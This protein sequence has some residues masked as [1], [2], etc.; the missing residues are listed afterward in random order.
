MPGFSMPRLGSATM[1]ALAAALLVPALGGWQSLHTR[2]AIL[3]DAEQ[4]TRT[5]SHSLAQHAARTIEA[6]DLI[7]SDVV[8]RVQHPDDQDLQAYLV[9][10]SKT[11]HQS[12][13]IVVTNALGR[14]VSDSAALQPPIDIA[15]SVFFA[16]HASHDTGD[17][18][19]GGLSA[20]RLTNEPFLPLSKRITDKDGAF[21]GVAV[22]AVL[23]RFFQE[24]YRSLDVG[25]HGAVGL[26]DVGGH[27]LVR[28]PAA[29]ETHKP[30]VNQP[31]IADF[32]KDRTAVLRM[33]SPIDGVERITV[34]E[35]VDA[36]PLVVTAAVSMNDVLA[37][38]RRDVL[39]EGLVAGCA[40]FALAGFAFGLER[41]RRIA[42][43]SAA[44]RREADRKYRVL[45][46]T[47]SDVIMQISLDMRREYVSPAC[48]LMV[49]H[50]PEDMVGRDPQG[51]MH[52][53]DAPQVMAKLR[54]VVNGTAEGDTHRATYRVRHKDGHWVWVD[55]IANLLR[56]AHTGAPQTVISSL[57]DVTERERFARHLERAKATAE[58]AARLQSEFVANMSH[59]LRTPLTGILGIHDLLKRDPTLGPQQRR[60]LDMAR[61]AGRSLLSIVN[62]V[63]DFS[64]IE[65]GQLAIEQVPFRLDGLVE[66]CAEL[67]GESAKEKG[68]R[69]DTLAEG[70]D[71]RLVGDP[72]RLRQVLLNLTANAIKFTESGAVTV[73]ASYRSEAA[74]MRIEVTD[75]GIGIAEDKLPFMFARFSQADASTTRRYGGTG[76]GLAICKRIIE[77]MGGEIGVTS[78][79]GRGSTFWVDVPLLMAPAEAEQAKP[80]A[81]ES[82]LTGYRVLLAEDNLVNQEL[83]AAILTQRGH[84]VTPVDN[85]AA[86]AAAART[87]PRFDLILMDIQ[88][89]VMDGLTATGVIRGAEVTD[90]HTA[91][92]IIGLTANAMLEDVERCLQAGMTAH[93]AKPIDWAKLFATIDRVAATETKQDTP[94]ASGEEVPATVLHAAKLDDLVAVMGR[95]RV[96]R[97]LGA[98]VQDL[99]ARLLT[100]DGAGASGLRDQCHALV[101][102]AGQFGF[103]ELGRLCAEVEAAARSGGGLDRVSDL[104]AVAARAISAAWNYARAEAA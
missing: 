89:P 70:A 28:F 81:M 7:L 88:M 60:Y 99:D 54:A 29:P 96:A 45:A 11:L 19:V 72:A 67:T 38:W 41:Q 17:L 78:V 1:M 27:L 63:L 25:P 98:F 82:P 59:E 44:A 93:V 91:I 46:E 26:W 80:N 32:P 13:T 76:L 49:G 23:P 75:T 102:T 56:D 84:V 95:D 101:S 34:F 35:H 5:L 48:R 22:A 62:D 51:H 12:S 36:Y 104:R 71:V 15:D 61:D 52:P 2:D 87:L 83:I 90:G 43:R 100:L 47:T 3:D 57:R 21:A 50:A 85:G 79:V 39:N 37:K 55:A 24:F 66:S 8:E 65:A 53:E 20:S 30:G 42:L 9:R 16:W 94:A 18:V 97:L 64:K 92:P 58:N 68:L 40:S 33:N 73:H 4:N 14:S 74:R 69:F 31:T 86:A 10:R 6:V 77:L 103:A